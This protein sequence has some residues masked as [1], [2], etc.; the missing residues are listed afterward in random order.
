MFALLVI[1]IVWTREMNKVFG[2]VREL[3]QM[4][5]YFVRLGCGSWNYVKLMQVALFAEFIDTDDFSLFGE[6]C[7]IG[8]SN[9]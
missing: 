4:T 7:R 1:M 8:G 6:W 5:T 2:R 3:A 9:V